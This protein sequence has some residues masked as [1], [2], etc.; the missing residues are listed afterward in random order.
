[1]WVQEAVRESAGVPPTQ[2]RGSGLLLDGLEPRVLLTSISIGGISIPIPGLPNLPSLT[3]FPIDNLPI[4]LNTLSS[5]TNPNSNDYWWL[6]N[7]GQ[8]LDDAFEGPATGK[9]GADIDAT[10]A[11]NITT[12]S[13]R[14]VVAV[15]DTGIDAEVTPIGIQSSGP[16][17]GTLRAAI[18]KPETCTDGISSITPATCRTISFTEPPSPRGDSLRR[19]QCHPS[20]RS[21]SAPPPGQAAQDVDE[22]INY[23][24]RPQKSHGVNIVAINASLFITYDAPTQG[25][26]LN[27]S[28]SRMPETTACSMPPPRETPA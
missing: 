15:L 22:G 26:G 16:T 28:P 14:L 6:N 25:H 5:L 10:D 13:P 18:P 24:D 1:M 8:T 21:R 27:L 17:R 3:S 7:T 4:G 19:P 9:A 23:L 20:F 12:G 11:W 2:M